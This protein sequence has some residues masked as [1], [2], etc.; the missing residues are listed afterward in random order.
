MILYLCSALLPPQATPGFRSRQRLTR[1]RRIAAALEADDAT[2]A[3][4][5]MSPHIQIASLTDHGHRPPLDLLQDHAQ[6]LLIGLA[7]GAARHAAKVVVVDPAQAATVAQQVAAA[8]DL[9]LP[10]ERP[11]AGTLARLELGAVR[12]E[13]QAAPVATI[14]RTYDS[15]E[16]RRLDRMDARHLDQLLRAYYDGADS[17]C[18]MKSLDPAAGGGGGNGAHRAKAA[19]VVV[20]L[21][22]AQAKGVMAAARRDPRWV[23]RNSRGSGGGAGGGGAGGMGPMAIEERLSAAARTNAVVEARYRDMTWDECG[24][25]A[26]CSSDAAKRTWR[27]A[28]GAICDALRER[29]ALREAAARDMA[30]ADTK[31]ETARE[32]V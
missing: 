19:Q 17:V 23:G 12:P 29:V 1:L 15:S 4:Q 32:V 18:G 10:V 22:I 7:R 25:V 3:T 9:G 21:S 6:A 11:D 31:T 30:G 26:G 14:V 16:D 20:G 5:V 13:Q 28:K 8:K 2:G 27:R 24:E